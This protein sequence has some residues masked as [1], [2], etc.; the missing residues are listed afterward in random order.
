MKN[1]LTVKETKQY[2]LIA[3]F[4]G[5]TEDLSDLIVGMYHRTLYPTKSNKFILIEVTLSQIKEIIESFNKENA[6]VE[7]YNDSTCIISSKTLQF[8]TSNSIS[9][10]SIELGKTSTLNFFNEI[11]KESSNIDIE[12]SMFM[13]KHRLNGSTL[14]QDKDGKCKCTLCKFTFDIDQSIDDITNA[15]KVLQDALQTIKAIN[16]DLAEDQYKNIGK[17]IKQIIEIPKLYEDSRNILFEE[18]S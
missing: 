15:S 2:Q 18:E 14:K 6:Y 11:I 4:N 8:V 12:E 9:T 7:L 5:L 3:T 16:I 10:Y 1:I 13:C 17:L